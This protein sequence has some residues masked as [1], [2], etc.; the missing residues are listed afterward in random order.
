[1]A[2]IGW[3]FVVVVAL[4]FTFS[5][6]GALFLTH[7]FSGINKRDLLLFGITS[8]IPIALWWCVFTYAPFE[9]VAK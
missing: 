1:M 3:L 9:F 6:A 5:W 4:Y 2:I 7:G 8:L